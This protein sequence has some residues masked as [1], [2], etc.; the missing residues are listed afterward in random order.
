MQA[1][2]SIN[3]LSDEEVMLKFQSGY[4]KAFDVLVKRYQHRIHNFL[5]RYTHNDLDAEDL[6]QETF[7]RVYRCRNSYE[8]IAKFSTWLYTIAN[9]LAKSHYKKSS[10]MPSISIQTGYESD[11]VEQEF[12][13]PDVS[14]VPDNVVQ[15]SMNMELLEN[16]LNK[17]PVEFK[18]MI[19]LRD[20]QNLTYEEIEQI[21]GLA[22]GTV[23]SRINRGRVRLQ[24]M[25][26]KLIF[27][28]TISA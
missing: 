25:L 28:E 1:N 21:T 14:F 3:S 11:G 6:T 24:K 16:A 22:M 5:Y 19:V 26:G 17:L 13:L 4:D 27:P 7:Y 20:I 23:K 2:V 8:C 15:D 9:N 12:E 10:R 18:E